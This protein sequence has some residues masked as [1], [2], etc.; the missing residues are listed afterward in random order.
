MRRGH[1][2]ALE[3]FEPER[4]E[5]A[6]ESPGGYLD[7]LDGE[8]PSTGATQDLM[9]TRLVPTIYE[10]WWRPALGRVAKGLTGPG[11]DQELRIARLLLGLSAGHRV[12]DVACGPANFT[13]SFA[14]TVGHEGLA[15]GIDASPTMLA[16]GVEDT[17]R[18]GLENVALLRGDAG[19]LPFAAGSFDA[20]CCFAALHLFA[21]PEQALAEITRVL[22]PG[23][24]IAVMTSIRRGVAVGPLKPLI[25]RASGMKLFEADEVCAALDGLG[26]GE[27]HQRVSGMVQ[28]VGGRSPAGAGPGTATSAA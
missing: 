14:L 17:H 6:S 4:R 24:R 11:M 21:D 7:V 2:R 15:V 19:D 10:R 28:F 12:L 18:A 20:A 25:E 22:R 1:E 26:F 3:L 23:G 13:R 27:V 5:S 9:L 8:L 16:R